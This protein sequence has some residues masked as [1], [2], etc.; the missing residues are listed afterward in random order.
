KKWNE[1][2]KLKG[3]ESSHPFNSARTASARWRDGLYAEQRSDRFQNCALPVS[4]SRRAD[5][6]VGDVLDRHATC[7]S[8]RTLISLWS[9]S[10]CSPSMSRST[11]GTPCASAL[12]RRAATSTA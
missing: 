2:Q 10:D 3:A 8:E 11:S 7:R 4:F 12:F 9:S 1:R 5:A 6:S